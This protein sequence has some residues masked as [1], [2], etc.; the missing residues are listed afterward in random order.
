MRRM[1]SIFPLIVVL[2]VLTS[3]ALA[4]ETAKTCPSAKNAAATECAKAKAA[5]CT[6][7]Q[8]TC[9]EKQTALRKSLLNHKGGQLVSR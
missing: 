5:E 6:K 8:A 3:A 4:G 7:S 2:A 1:K 9:C